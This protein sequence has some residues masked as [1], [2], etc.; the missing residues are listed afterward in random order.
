VISGTRRLPRSLT[1]LGN[2][3]TRRSPA[4][5]TDGSR[6]AHPRRFGVRLVVLG[7]TAFVAAWSGRDVT[8]EL[9]AR[10]GALWLFDRLG[11]VAALIGA[12]AVWRRRW[13]LV[14]V[15]AAV[16]LVVR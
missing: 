8:W 15:A 7:V 9:P 5:T 11:V 6:P 3:M 13:W 14:V 4:P 2:E 10:L 1:R 12:V 16:W